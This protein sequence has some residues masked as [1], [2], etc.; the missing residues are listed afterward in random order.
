[1]P[2]CYQNYYSLPL[3]TF[4]VGKS[5]NYVRGLIIAALWAHV[6]QE[7][8]LLT[9]TTLVFTYPHII[10]SFF[11]LVVPRHVSAVMVGGLF[12]WPA[13]RYGTGYQTV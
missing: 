12:L 5:V 11:Q 6:V 2:L 10:S 3:F 9:Y 4:Y 7:R 1:M 13:L 8:T